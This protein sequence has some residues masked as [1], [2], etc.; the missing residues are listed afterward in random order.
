[1]AKTNN[2]TEF[3]TDIADTIRAK[4]G[5]TDK[6]N[7][8]NFSVEISGIE[9]GITPTGEIEITA[10]GNY[11][12]T[13][14]ASANV[15]VDSG[16]SEDMLQARVDATNSCAHLFYS[17]QGETL[18][19]AKNL[20]TS[21]VTSMTEMFRDCSH[22][23]E[24]DV[25]YLDTSN[26]TQMLGMFQ[27]C[28]E[29]NSTLDLSNFDT[30][31]V[32]NMGN[33]FYGCNNVQK[34]IVDDFDTSNVTSMQSMFYNCNDLTE[35]NVSKW[36]T[37]KVTRMSS[38]FYYC[39]TLKTLDL[40]KW[41]TSSLT[42]LT[43]AFALCKNL[44]SLNVSNFNLSKLQTVASVFDGLN[45]ITTLDLSSWDLSNVKDSFSMM[46]R[47][48]YK[49]QN[50]IGTINMINASQYT[51]FVANCYALENITVKNVKKALQLGSG[52]SYGHLLSLDSLINAVKELWDY[53]SG[54]TT[55]KLTIGSA[56]LEKIA[57]VYVKLITPT[58]EQIEADPN[59]ESKLPCEVCE[60]T[61]DGAMLITDYATLK[62]WTI[63]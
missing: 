62:K 56:N 8:Q 48:C 4:K 27:N 58:A 12:V 36:D 53:S 57:D 50:V 6:I 17:Y 34:I 9:T 49:L 7:P 25:S 43:S 42:S 44:T 2:L 39:Q 16:S 31:K 15:N 55:Y 19:F 29:L 22:L 46:F 45:S 14:Y 11:D 51:S 40:S 10:N 60:S 21:N 52:T 5:T 61:D 63:A 20:N 59:I 35:L 33:M 28:N 32:I 26:V 37:S 54:T 18:D 23:K 41:D 47:N 30:S 38:M 3:L 13:N 1:M 24:L